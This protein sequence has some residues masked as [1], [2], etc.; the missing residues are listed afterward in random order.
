M[1]LVFSHGI[2]TPQWASLGGSNGKESAC[3]VGDWGSIPQ[4]G[5]SPGEGKGYPLQYSGLENSMD[6]TVLIEFCQETTLVI[7]NPL[8]TT[9]EKTAHGHHQMANTEIRLIIFF[10]A[11]DREAL[12]SQQKQDW[13]LTVA[14]IMNAS[15]QNSNLN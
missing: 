15:L 12:C 1:K 14:Q 5:R 4:L 2:T 13:E 7:A 8:P 9:Q 11:K 3:N 6:C 10:A